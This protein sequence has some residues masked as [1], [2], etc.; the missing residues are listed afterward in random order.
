MY[1]EMHGEK[2]REL[3]EEKGLARRDLAAAAG[4]SLSTVNRLERETPVSFRTARRVILAPGEEPSERGAR[5]I[6]IS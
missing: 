5:V 3:R 4:I 6:R 2:V 1:V